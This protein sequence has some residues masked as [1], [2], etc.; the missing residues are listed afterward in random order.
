MEL[1]KLMSEGITTETLNLMGKNFDPNFTHKPTNA[2]DI[3]CEV[4]YNIYAEK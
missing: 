1:I 2:K 4:L 3:F